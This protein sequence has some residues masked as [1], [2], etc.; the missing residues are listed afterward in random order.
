[1]IE[2]HREKVYLY[3][4]GFAAA[5][6][7]AMPFI[8]TFNEMLT[9]IVEQTGLFSAIQEVLAPFM[10]K[11]LVVVLRVMGIPA[12]SG[13]SSLYLTNSFIPLQIYI[14]WNCIGW[15]SFI[16]LAFTLVTGLQGSYTT[17]SKILTIIYGLEGTFLLNIIRILI[18][19][20]L[21]YIWGYI[22]AVLFHDYMGTV[23]T[24]LWLGLFWKSSFSK[25]LVTNPKTGDIRLSIYNYLDSKENQNRGIR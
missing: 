18:P 17:R 5:S 23:L 6:F 20:M 19:T 22:P 1:M 21:A 15:Q 3:L 11:I 8:N 9:K 14:N 4:L 25:V 7:M 2:E 12:L 10:V 16:L 24:L 13:G